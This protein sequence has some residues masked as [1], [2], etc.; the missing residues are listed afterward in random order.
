ME[1]LQLAQDLHDGP[2]QDLQAMNFEISIF[3]SLIG[4]KGTEELKNMRAELDR[5][6]K[7]IRSICGELRPPA[8]APFGLEKAIRSHAEHF[9]ELHPE[10]DFI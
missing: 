5:V 8:L 2:L 9:Q 3:E 1:R 6:T 10:F 7:S 4:E